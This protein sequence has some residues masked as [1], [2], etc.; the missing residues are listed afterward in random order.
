MTSHITDEQLTHLHKLAALDVNPAEFDA[1]RN[2][3]NNI[4]D[5]VQRLDEVDVEG[6]AP[7]AHPH[8]DVTLECR[9]GV[10]ACDKTEAL[11]SNVNHLFP[12]RQLFSIRH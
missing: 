5:L 10:V 11:L 6:I 8:D 1:L 12:I 7:M 4:I 3:L 2:D 9:E